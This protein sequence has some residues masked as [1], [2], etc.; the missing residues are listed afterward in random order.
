MPKMIQPILCTNGNILTSS[1]KEE[2]NP[3]IRLTLLLDISN[4]THYDG[5]VTLLK[6][7]CIYSMHLMLHVR[8]W[9]KKD[10]LYMSPYICTY[11][12][13]YTYIFITIKIKYYYIIDFASVTG[14][15]VVA[16]IYNY[17][18]PLSIL[19][20]F[21]LQQRLQLVMTPWWNGSNLH[22]WGSGP[23]VALPELGYFNFPL[24]L[25]TGHGNIKLP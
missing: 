16:G 11:I 13:T 23:S 15:M 25:I 7:L 22:S 5:K 14:H 21:G 4:F 3:W 24:T 17:L 12:Y 19:Y 6:I 1:P 9:E 10:I 20:F 18:L 8:K 2:V